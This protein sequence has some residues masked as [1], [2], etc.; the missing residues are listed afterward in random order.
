MLVNNAGVS[1]RSAFAET[2]GSVDLEKKIMNINFFAH[3]AMT[4][5]VYTLLKA[6]EGQ[7]VMM[8]S[9]AGLYGSPLRSPYSASK[10]A[11]QG[12]FE[13]LRTELQ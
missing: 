8:S 9:V 13:S 10:F 5:S 4:K 3:I 12:Y 11:I 2:L 1:S 7:I 6:S